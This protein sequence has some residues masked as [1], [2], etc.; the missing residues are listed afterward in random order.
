MKKTSAVG[1]LHE[2]YESG[3]FFF[4]M[5][6]LFSVLVYP[7]PP[8]FLPTTLE[9]PLCLGRA[10]LFDSAYPFFGMF[11]TLYC[12]F[13]LLVSLFILSGYIPSSALNSASLSRT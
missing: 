6:G 13:N 12:H 11:V 3:F 10:Y 8:P 1:Y 7:P 5:V 4:F 2:T 9:S